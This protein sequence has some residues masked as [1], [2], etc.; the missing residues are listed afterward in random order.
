MSLTALESNTV[1]RALQAAKLTLEQ[2]KPVLDSLDVIY[3]SAGGAKT[4]ITQAG[5]DEIAS[6]SGLTK[7]QLDDGMFAL[8]GTL[9]NDIV[10]AYTALAQLAARAGGQQ[11]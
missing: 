10:N 1:S 4:T 3:N 11:L 8:T 6:F 5:L 2:L 9:K 7:T